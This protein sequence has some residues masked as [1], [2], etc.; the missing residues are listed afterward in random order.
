MVIPE[1]S[2]NQRVKYDEVYPS[3]AQVYWCT[4]H[5]YDIWPEL[6]EHK[7]S[8]CVIYAGLGGPGFNARRPANVAQEIRDEYK[9]GKRNFI[10]QTLDEGVAI[11]NILVIHAAINLIQDI[12]SDIVVM[13]AT[14]AFDGEQVYNQFC[15]LNNLEPKLKIISGSNFEK[16]SKSFL[17]FVK[18]YVPG[19]REKLFLCFNKE[20]RQHRITLLNELLGLDLVKKAYYSFALNIHTYYNIKTMRDCPYTNILKIIDELPM[21]LNRT[22]ERWNPID[23]RLDDLQYF[24]NSY[25]SVINETVF[26]GLNKK[27]GNHYINISEILGAFPSE[28]I[29]KAFALKHP[30]IMVGAVGFLKKM[31]EHGYKT[32]SPFIDETYD[33]VEDDDERMKMIIKEIH[34]MCSLSEQELIEFTHNVKSIVEHNCQHYIDASDYRITK[35]VLSMLK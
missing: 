11:A 27:E 29:Y 3:E 19:P 12:I 9:L 8:I 15:K 22:E 30:F 21:V 31:R 35:N 32:F 24:D 14:G 1:L 4:R 16:N 26:Y 23:V 17:D 5:V 33:D 28:K 10:F 6:L 13:Y 34:R 2:D 18:P 7:D 20:P 25:F